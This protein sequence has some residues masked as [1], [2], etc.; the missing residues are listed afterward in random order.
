MKCAMFENKVYLSDL[1]TTAG[2][3]VN[4]DRIFGSTVLVTGATGMIGAFLV[5]TLMQANKTLGA[6]VK[7]IA[8]G[9]RKQKLKE[10]FAHWDLDDCSR[11]LT[12]AEYDLLQELPDSFRNIEADYVIH[13]AGNAY[14]SAF[15]DHPQETVEGNL[16]GTSRLLEYSKMHGVKKFIY[17]SS[18]EVYSVP[19]D[20]VM[21]FKNELALS[22]DIE[23]FCEKVMERVTA[24]GMRTCYPY[25]KVAAEAICM[26][27]D[28]AK[29]CTLTRLCHTFGPGASPADDRAHAQFARRA[30][31]GENIVLNSAGTQERSYN[32]VADAASG[33]LSCMTSGEAGESY[34]IC[35]AG[36]VISIRGLAELMAKAAG[37]QVIVREADAREERLKSP[38]MKQILDASKLE[39][40]GWEKAYNLEDST[41]RYV[42]YLSSV[43]D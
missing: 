12:F 1:K 20:T 14:P 2:H 21:C 5:D 38:I 6:D 26:D 30:A 33:I 43:A 22:E 11:N 4:F 37:V 10:R 35:S 40:L 39:K 7:A 28:N 16:I 13:V 34:D 18:G 3:V 31:L 9:R 17:I 42:E 23:G 41:A 27:P 25:S 32:Y 24:D 19:E 36:N 29:F 8:C 15:V